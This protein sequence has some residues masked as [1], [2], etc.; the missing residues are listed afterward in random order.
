MTRRRRARKNTDP[1]AF[2]DRKP[3]RN[4]IPD[5]QKQRKPIVFLMSRKNVAD[6]LM[7]R[8]LAKGE[9][10]GGSRSLVVGRKVKL[11]R[12]FLD[13]S[14]MV[15]PTAVGLILWLRMILSN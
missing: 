14:P 2:S 8:I 4:R 6:P 9:G 1:R 15:E 5:H 7:S 10:E 11:P 13:I 3:L 12:F